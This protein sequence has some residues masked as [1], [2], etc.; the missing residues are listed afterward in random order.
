ME[1]RP[2]QEP[3]RRPSTPGRKSGVTGGSPTPPWIWVFLIAVV[4][5][6]TYVLSGKNET[7]VNF[8]PWFME[9]VRADNVESLVTEGLLVHGKLRKPVPYAPPAPLPPIPEVLKF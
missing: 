5:L 4:A 2:P 8:S 1:S 9:Q 3:S 7:S 6:V